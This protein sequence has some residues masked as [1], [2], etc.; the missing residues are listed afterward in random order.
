MPQKNMPTDASEKAEAFLKIK[1]G[2]DRSQKK[3]I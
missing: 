1:Q 3:V 2:W